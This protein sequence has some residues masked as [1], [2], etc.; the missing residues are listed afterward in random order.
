M[1]L[2]LSLSVF[3]LLSELVSP[4]LG[5]SGPGRRPAGGVSPGRLRRQ[6][7]SQMSRI[8]GIFRPTGGWFSRD[9]ATYPFYLCTYS[10]PPLRCPGG[11]LAWPCLCICRDFSFVNGYINPCMRACAWVIMMCKHMSGYTQDTSLCF[12]SVSVY[13]ECVCVCVRVSECITG[14]QWLMSALFSSVSWSVPEANERAPAFLC[15]ETLQKTPKKS[16]A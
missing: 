16:T 12:S 14:K 9:V 5:L 1:S 11:L 8:K 15:P 7:H 6:H 4:L 10:N 3:H 2:S 13:S